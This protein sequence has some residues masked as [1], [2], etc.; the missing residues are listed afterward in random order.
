MPKLL[1]ALKSVGG[2]IGRV[3]S[4]GLGSVALDAVRGAFDETLSD[5]AIASLLAENDPTALAAIRQAEIALQGELRALDVEETKARLVDRQD[6]RAMQV[7]TGSSFQNWLAASLLICCALIF[8]V[9]IF[10]PLSG[11]KLQTVNV[12]FGMM[13]SFLGMAVAYYFGSSKRND[14]RA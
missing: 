10:A 4:G 8:G 1:D 11:E 14:E 7:Q 5:D 13:L 12:L 2:F 9:I 3:A 6:A